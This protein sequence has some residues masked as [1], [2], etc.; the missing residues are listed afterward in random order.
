MIRTLP[1]AVLSLVA[2]ASLLV[3]GVPATVDAFLAIPAD[4]VLGK[5]QNAEPV[6]EAELS[7]T[8]SS[9]RQ[10]LSWG[11]TGRKWTDLALAQFLLAEKIEHD[12]EASVSLLA[13]GLTSLKNGL[14]LAP[15]NPFAWTRLAYVE[16]LKSGPSASVVP[17][18]RM[19]INTAPYEPRLLFPRLELC[20]NVWPYLDAGVRDL[21]IR[22]VLF[23]WRNDA[24]GLV[25]LA[26]DYHRV[27]LVRNAL[28]KMPEELARFEALLRRPR[29]Q[30]M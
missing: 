14:A 24:D 20:F 5:I 11:E 15:A 17:P 7:S 12:Q 6:S 8:I 16:F 19:A 23:A 26:R 28:S 10:S 21:V 2:G 3:L 30:E 18:L 29:T 9:Q 1:V 25:I 13:D 27:D 4:R 22:Q